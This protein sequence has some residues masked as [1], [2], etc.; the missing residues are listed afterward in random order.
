MTRVI[1]RKLPGFGIQPWRVTCHQCTGNHRPFW[2][3]ATH[4][5][6]GAIVYAIRHA[7]EHRSYP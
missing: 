5:A 1:V 3:A 7:N 4:T 2:Q 6:V